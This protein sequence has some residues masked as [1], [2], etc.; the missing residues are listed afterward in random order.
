MTALTTAG[1]APALVQP[2]EDRGRTDIAERVVERIAQ[3]VVLEAEHASGAARRLLG[4]ALGSDDDADTPQ[5]TVSIDGQLT[6]IQLTMCVAYPMPVRRVT[7]QVRQDVI[8]RI[9]Y[10][11]GLEV[12]HVDISITR[13]TGTGGERRVR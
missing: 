12:R 10:L 3:Q 2:A 11:T 8:D 5:V 6:T 7:R 1:P 9:G 4:V 13:L